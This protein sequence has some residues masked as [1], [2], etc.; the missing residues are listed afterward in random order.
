MQAP[1]WGAAS[2]RVTPTHPAMIAEDALA[3][4]CS[5][6]GRYACTTTGGE[7]VDDVDQFVRPRDFHLRLRRVS[8]NELRRRRPRH[9][10]TRTFG[11]ALGH[12]LA[13]C[14]AV[15][16]DGSP[17]VRNRLG[18]SFGCSVRLMAPQGSN[19][20]PS[21]CL[22]RRASGGRRGGRLVRS[23]QWHDVPAEM[24]ARPDPPRAARTRQVPGTP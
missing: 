3:E 13:A 19:H 1:R 5:L 15:E 12:G 24:T 4:P 23:I 21:G 22:A 8:D 9:G 17:R 6:S 16:S 7:R 11:S 20:A 10:R 2:R 18:Q 14:G